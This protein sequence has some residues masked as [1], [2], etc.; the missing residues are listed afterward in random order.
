MPGPDGG[1]K[2]TLQSTST[3]H[4]FT[5]DIRHLLTLDDSSLLYIL[6]ILHSQC[7]LSSPNPLCSHSVAS[8][9][10]APRVASRN[11]T[12]VATEMKANQSFA[13]TWLSDQ[14][15]YPILAILL[16]APAG[17][18]GFISYKFTYCPNVRVTSKT[19]KYQRHCATVVPL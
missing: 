18:L 2:E 13:K 16:I 9:A 3:C 15:A 17:A 11:I 1:A 14:S 12:S 4:H 6:Y 5:F 10:M 7:S 8:M 19:S